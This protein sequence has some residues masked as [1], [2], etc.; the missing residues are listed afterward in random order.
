MLPPE[1]Y[2]AA[3]AAASHWLQLRIIGV[4]KPDRLPVVAQQVEL[5]AK[6]GEKPTFS[7]KE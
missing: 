2:Q 3:G 1:E 7:G 4:T 5:V 6:P